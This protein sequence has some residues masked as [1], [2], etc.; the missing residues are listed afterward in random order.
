VGKST[1][2][3]FYLSSDFGQC[4]VVHYSPVDDDVKINESILII[5]PFAEELNNSRRMIADQARLLAGEGFDVL[6][7]DFF[8][9]GDSQGEFVEASWDIWIEN[10][11]KAYAWLIEVS[12]TVHFL[13]V[14]T[15]SLLA[16]DFL[17]KYSLDV[18]DVV[19]WQ[20]VVSGELFIKQLLRIRI[21]SQAFRGIKETS[22]A[23][24][25]ELEVRDVIEISGYEINRQLIQS[26][27]GRKLSLEKFNVNAMHVIEIG[28]GNSVGVSSLRAPQAKIFTVESVNGSQYW[29][30]IEAP[31]SYALL[32]ATTR[33]MKPT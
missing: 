7:L 26:I 16:V 21:A 25:D 24:L 3:P 20:P 17:S 6:C 2:N 9:T 32:Q 33:R 14:R 5:P 23:L 1:I 18:K 8:G 13:T 27:S 31:I 4:F 29:A 22:Q 19:M 10:L 28:V 30:N 12:S 15:G 11:H